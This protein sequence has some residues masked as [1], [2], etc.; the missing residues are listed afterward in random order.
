M[1]D[2]K[3]S[4]RGQ[5][6]DVSK[7]LVAGIV[8]GLAAAWTMNQ[9]Q[10]LLS[11]LV[12]GQE[13]SHGAQSLQQ[14]SP[15]RGAGRELQE[16]G[17]EDETD[18][19]TE[20]LANIVSEGVFD[21]QLTEGEKAIAGTAIH[22]GFGVTSGALYGVLAELAPG[23][24]AG[25]G[26]PFGATIWLTADEGMVPL[27]GLSKSPTEYPPSVHAYSLASHFVFGLT[28]ELVRRAVRDAL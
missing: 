28:T 23:V 26:L 19:A 12:E 11:K 2:N 7:G 5:D 13:R 16:R 10:A 14:G 18:D 27:L 15:Q 9:F 6:G 20:R 17:S 8:A 22:Y 24:K 1:P 3:R 4:G 21:H 25:A